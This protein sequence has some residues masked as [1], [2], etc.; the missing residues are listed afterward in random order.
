MPGEVSL[1]IGA[2]QTGVALANL[3]KKRNRPEYNA[4]P[5]LEAAYS[6][7]LGR[8]KYGYTGNQV[9]GFKQD[10][11]RNNNQQFSKATSQFGNQL[12][13]VATAGINFGNISALNNF[14][15]NDATLMGEHVRNAYG[16][17]D[18][19]QR[20]ADMNT[21]AAIQNYNQNQQAWGHALESGI[22]NTAYGVNS[23]LMK[24]NPA[25]PNVVVNPVTGQPAAVT[26]GAPSNVPQYDN[27]FDNT[28]TT[29]FDPTFAP[30]T[31][32]FKKGVM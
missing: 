2:I 29:L 8:T 13:G 24:N 6:D 17:A 27:T 23:Q 3:L 16:I 10:L 30:S 12:G 21:T 26:T 22:Y 19:F 14:Y 32:H 9:L 1:A 11:Q 31:S 5:Q 7:A 15:K 25:D 4:A 20:I 18:K 28:D